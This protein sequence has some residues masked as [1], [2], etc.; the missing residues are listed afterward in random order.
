MIAWISAV[1]E[2]SRSPWVDE[3]RCDGCHNTPGHDYEQPGTLY[4]NSKGHM[5]ISCEACHGS[6]H[7]IGPSVVDRDNVQ[8]IMHQGKAGTINSCLVCHRS[9]PDEAFPHRL[10]GD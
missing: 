9:Q 10:S 1:G 5:G 3:P 7:A 6:T 4:R 8:A 2:P